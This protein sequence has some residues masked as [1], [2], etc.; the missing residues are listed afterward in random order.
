[1]RAAWFLAVALVSCAGDDLG[2]LSSPIISGSPDPGHESVGAMFGKDGSLCTGTLIS[3]K[4][5]L[6]AA[7]CLNAGAGTTYVPRSVGFGRSTTVGE[8]VQVT[9]VAA[10]I[11]PTYD[12]AHEFVDDLGVIVLRDRVDK[13]PVPVHFQVPKVGEEVTLVGFGRRD[14]DVLDSFGRKMKITVPVDAVSA[15]GIQ[16]K[17]VC[18]GDSGGP[19]LVNANGVE[20]VMG[21]ISYGDSGCKIYGVAQRVDTF[22]SWIEQQI[23]TNDPPS[24]E[25]DARCRNDCPTGDADCPCL[26]GDGVCS[27]LCTDPASDPECPRGCGPG[28]TCVRGTT[29]PAPDPDCGDPCGSEGH[30]VETCATRDPDCPAPKPAGGSCARTFECEA[31]MSCVTGTCQKVC[32]PA[33]ASSCGAD[34]VCTRL[35][36]E[37]AVCQPKPESDDGGCA[38]GHGGGSSWL[39]LL[40]LAVFARRRPALLVLLL[41]S[42]PAFAAPPSPARTAGDT[43]FAAA[44]YHEAAR[45]YE[46]AVGADPDD[47]DS[48]YRLG[49]ARAA[50]GDLPRAVAAWESVLAVEPLHELARRNL[51]LARLRMPVAPAPDPEQV[52]RRARVLL[53][54]GRAAS[55]LML[56]DA[57]A[58]SPDVLAL[59]AEAQ[60]AVGD[61]AAALSTARALLAAEPSEARPY[62]LLAAARNL[63]GDA[64]GA[65]YFDDLRR[66]HE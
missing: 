18:S 11:L 20:E 13:P 45:A 1:M 4:V 55:A 12:E 61:P 49:V 60:L 6:T 26:A 64:A 22:R 14:P 28:D 17:G 53:D 9:A 19:A 31:P 24:C 65:R 37:T 40:L 7:H 10:F 8:N 59:R 63:A 39:V 51:D 29:C 38:T 3:S 47:V 57:V 23:A 30:C 35:S 58:T 54:E 15:D 25:K 5:V 21:V 34:A 50:A 27:A 2:S 46:A 32:D 66:A 33:T 36:P 41:A 56:L 44:R 52:R 43:A 16:V 62:R 42:A 48:R